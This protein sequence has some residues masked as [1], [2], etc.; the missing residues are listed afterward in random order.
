MWSS[1]DVERIYRSL[2]VLDSKIIFSRRKGGPN[3]DL[4]K[5]TT[6]AMDCLLLRTTRL[7][8]PIGKT[9]EELSKAIEETSDIE[10]RQ[11]LEE[12]TDF[13]KTLYTGDE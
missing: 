4:I 7:R 6:N 5:N 9:L 1:K 12:V 13:I 2:S 3:Q 11:H 8:Q 10:I